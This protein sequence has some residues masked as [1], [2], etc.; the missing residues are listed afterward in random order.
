MKKIY[1][2]V[3]GLIGGLSVM[4]NQTHAATIQ[5]Y[6]PMATPTPIQKFRDVGNVNTNTINVQLTS[7]PSPTLTSK[8]TSK[9]T[10]TPTPKPTSK[11]TATPTPKPT[12]K[13]TPKPTAKP[14]PKTTPK[15]TGFF[16]TIQIDLIKIFQ[17]FFG[18]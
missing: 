8:P 10:A 12:A 6:N 14:T 5:R 3:A 15:S 2:I 4:A 18:K 17:G 9:P 13:P 1:K 16:Q 7:K 11:P